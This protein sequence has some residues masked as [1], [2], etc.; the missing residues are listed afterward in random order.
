MPGLHRGL[1]SAAIALARQE[2]PERTDRKLVQAP[3]LGREPRLER[4]LARHEPLEQLWHRL[5]GV[6]GAVGVRVWTLCRGDGNPGGAT[7]PEGRSCCLRSLGKLRD[8]KA[9][10]PLVN[11]LEQ[12]EGS[13]V[14]RRASWALKD[15]GGA[16]A[17]SAL[18]TAVVGDPDEAVREHAVGALAKSAGT[19]AVGPLVRA[20][21]EDTSTMVRYEA[22][23]NLAEIGGDR[24]MGAFRQALEDPHELVRAKAEE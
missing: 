12:D 9:L 14:R 3:T 20:L 6:P 8:G 19:E 24:A 4:R 11:A 15:I 10:E 16:M 5:L 21:R 1:E 22:L 17:G 2:S 7:R 23:V 18:A 13:G